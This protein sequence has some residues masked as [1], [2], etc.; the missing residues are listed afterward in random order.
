VAEAAEGDNVGEI[1]PEEFGG[2]ASESSEY[3]MRVIDL[4]KEDILV[5]R[6]AMAS[7]DG[8]VSRWQATSKNNRARRLIGR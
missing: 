6:A 5:F 8:E 7:N 2:I 4:R 3:D 1:E